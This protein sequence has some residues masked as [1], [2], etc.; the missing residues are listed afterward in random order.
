MNPPGTGLDKNAEKARQMSGDAETPRRGNAPGQ[1]IRG[2]VGR[3]RKASARDR[4]PARAGGG[5]KNRNQNGR[6]SGG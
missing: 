1:G 6:G 4:G 5:R 2:F 3:K